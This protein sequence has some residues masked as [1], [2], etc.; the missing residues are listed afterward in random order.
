MLQATSQ[1]IEQE[2]RR[3][4]GPIG[5]FHVMLATNPT[6]H[7]RFNGQLKGY[8]PT[9]NYLKWLRTQKFRL[10]VK[11]KDMDLYGGP[12]KRFIDLKIKF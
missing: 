7:V 10:K 8:K 4:R 5:K 2:R 9:V 12:L 3:E 1:G 6:C 11:Q